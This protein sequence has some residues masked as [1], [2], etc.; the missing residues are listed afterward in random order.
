MSSLPQTMKAAVLFDYGDLRIS[1]VEMPTPGEHEVLISV[2]ACAI[3]GSDPKGLTRA[4][5]TSR[6]FLGLLKNLMTTAFF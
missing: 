6:N 2:E 5:K 1:E 4:L 3:C